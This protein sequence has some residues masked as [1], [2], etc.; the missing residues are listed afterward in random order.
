MPRHP[1]MR[2]PPRAALLD[3]L[4]SRSREPE[5]SRSSDR[6]RKRPSLD[7][8]RMKHPY[9]RTRLA[10]SRRDTKLVPF[11]S[12]DH[13]S[14][15]GLLVGQQK[16]ASTTGRDRVGMDG[17]DTCVLGQEYQAFDRHLLD[18]HRIAHGLCPFGVDLGHRLDPKPRRT[19]PLRDQE[20]SERSVREDRGKLRLARRLLRVPQAR[21]R[22]LVP[23]R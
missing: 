11:E 20:I 4:L 1:V 19:Q 23:R 3:A 10:C 6:A 9:R 15:R 5:R 14:C 12:R 8:G 17:T 13:I 7:A 18:P 22:S 21:F 2:L 16:H